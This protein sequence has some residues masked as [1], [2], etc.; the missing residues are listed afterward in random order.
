TNAPFEHLKS[1]DVADGSRLAPLRAS[2]AE[3]FALLDK[4]SVPR[5]SLTFAWDFRTGSDQPIVD[6]LLSIRDRGLAAWDA[7]PTY[8][9][10]SMTDPTDDEH[11][12]R[13]VEGSFQVPRFL[14]DEGPFATFDLDAQGH[15]Q[16]HGT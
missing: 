15:P 16:M 5:A 1:G 12:L 8:A 13:V 11:L 2:Y 6:Q 9:I 4:Q 10:T 7:A 3:M 14:A